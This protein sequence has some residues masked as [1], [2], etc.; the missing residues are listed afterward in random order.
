M[1]E[2]VRGWFEL[3]AQGRADLACGSLDQ[4]GAQAVRWTAEAVLR[5]VH[6]TFGPGT[7]FAA[8]HA[9]GPRFTAPADA[10]GDPGLSLVAFTDGGGFAFDHSVPL[11]GAYSDLTAQF[12]F[13][14]NGD[15]LAVTLHDLHVL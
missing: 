14:W 15:R 3:L 10:T 12:E 13:R 4:D 9:E 6:E 1:T 5:L 11:N 2:F 7:V 8:A